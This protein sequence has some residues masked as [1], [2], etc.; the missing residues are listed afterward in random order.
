MSKSVASRYLSVSVR[1]AL[2]HFDIDLSIEVEAGSTLAIVGPSGAGKT[3]LLRC[4][5]GL[6]RPDTGY[7]RLEDSVCFDS[8][9]GQWV[10]PQRRRIALVNQGY[11]LFPHMTVRENL[12]FAFAGGTDPEELMRIAG[13]LHL[14]NRRPEHVS[15]GERQRAALCRVLAMRP[16]VLL[17]DEP[18]SA[19]DVENKVLFRQLLSEVR[20]SW[21]IPIVLVSH[22]LDD[23]ERT[24]DKV[25]A[26]RDGVIDQPWLQRQRGVLQDERDGVSEEAS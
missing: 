17:L 26:I 25:I 22:D 20:R 8:H 15:G 9:S 23:V 14:A 1:K 16:R 2:K 6:E 18:F 5:A 4:I 24:A 13:I 21:G 19:L 7:V 3:T 10:S 11:R 12:A